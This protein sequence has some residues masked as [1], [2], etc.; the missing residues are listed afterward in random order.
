MAAMEISDGTNMMVEFGLSSA[1][2]RRRWF[3]LAAMLA[4]AGNFTALGEL[5]NAVNQ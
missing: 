3:S 4:A 1:L 2:I 5:V